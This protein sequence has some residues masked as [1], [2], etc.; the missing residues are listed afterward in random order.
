MAIVSGRGGLKAINSSVAAED[1]LPFL[2]HRHAS[3]GQSTSS[4]SITVSA[5]R[6]MPPRAVSGAHQV[7]GGTASDWRRSRND[8][9]PEP[10]S[11]PRATTISSIR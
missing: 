8:G 1:V 10:A 9:A 4:G 6:P 11:G 2:S 3:R 7:G 5:L